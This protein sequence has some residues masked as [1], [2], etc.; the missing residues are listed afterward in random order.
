MY[1]NIGTKLNL[2]VGH[3][4]P[5]VDDTI[6]EA[7]QSRCLAPDIVKHDAESLPVNGLLSQR[8]KQTGGLERLVHSIEE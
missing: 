3:R 1:I 7:I 8:P 6:A 2:R 4:S 5:S